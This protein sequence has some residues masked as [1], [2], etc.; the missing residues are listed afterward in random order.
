M[1]DEDAFAQLPLAE[2]RKMQ[3]K[4]RSLD[5]P[6]EDVFDAVLSRMDFV[7]ITGHL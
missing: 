6:S 7:R 3:V 4:G 2:A 5:P 1:A